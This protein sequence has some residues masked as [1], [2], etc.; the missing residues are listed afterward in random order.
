[1]KN[2]IS[3]QTLSNIYRSLDILFSPKCVQC[4]T[5]AN[6]KINCFY[7]SQL[8]KTMGKEREW[9]TTYL[10]DTK[11]LSNQWCNQISIAIISYYQFR[12]TIEFPTYL[13]CCILH[14]DTTTFSENKLLEN[15]LTQI[16]LKD[17]SRYIMW[18][19]D[20][21]KQAHRPLTINIPCK[22]WSYDI[23]FRKNIL[24]KQWI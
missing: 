20:I 23:T 13:T 7:I 21:A 1:M 5:E 8:T 12:W 11:F 4:C 18:K 14:I 24:C 10:S 16:Y 3:L 2:D 22:M 6:K 9:T 17:L 19:V 15:G